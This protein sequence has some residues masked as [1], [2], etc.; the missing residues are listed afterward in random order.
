MSPERAVQEPFSIVLISL[1]VEEE[2]CA[3]LWL[4]MRRRWQNIS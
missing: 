4:R 3:C 2:T 1:I